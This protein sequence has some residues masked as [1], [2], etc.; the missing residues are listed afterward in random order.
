M[1]EVEAEWDDENRAWAIALLQVE[2]D[3]C[4]GCGEPLSESTHPDAED[5]YAVD[6]PTRCHACTALDQARAPYQDGRALYF[7][8]QRTW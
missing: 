6:L 1:T 2:A 7:E 8:V 5:G 4:R 3:T